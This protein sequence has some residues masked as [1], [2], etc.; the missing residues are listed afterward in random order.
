[1]STPGSG[2]PYFYEWYVGLSNV[3]EMLNPDSG[4]KSVTFQHADYDTV[5]DVVVEYTNGNIQFCYQIKHEKLTSNSTNLTFGKLIEKDSSKSSKASLI[6]S[7]FS[8]WVS[9]VSSSGMIIIPILYTNREAGI[10]RSGRTF[11]GEKYSA[12]SIHDFFTKLKDELNKINDYKNVKF[13]DKDLELQWKEFYDSIKTTDVEK[14]ISFVKALKIETNQPNLDDFEKV[15]I[16][17]LEKSFS[18]NTG[19]ATELFEK[20]VSALRKWTTAIWGGKPVLIEDAYDELVTEE[21]IC[22]AQ[23]RLAPPTPFFESRKDFCTDFIDTINSSDKKIIFVSGEPGSGKTSIMSYLQASN[24]LF[25]LRYHTFRPISPEQHFY[26]LDAGQCSPENLWGTLLIQ[27]RKKLKGHLY[28][29]NVPVNNKYLT[30]EQIREH[31]LRLLGIVS[32]Q[33]RKGERLFICIDGI[34]HAARA[35]N[36]ITFLSTLPKSVEIPD[37][38]C[39]VIV[40]QPIELYREQYPLWL[41]EEQ[42]VEKIM[43]P[44]LTIEDVIPLIEGKAGGLAEKATEVATLLFQYT[45]GN[46]LSTVFAIEEIKH[47]SCIEDIARVIS[48]RCISSDIQQYYNYIWDYVKDEIRKLNVPGIAP[49]SLVAC[50]ILLLNGQ[51][52]IRI[53]ANA[54]SQSISESDWRVIFN[55]LFPLIYETDTSGVYALFHNDFRVFLM[56]QISNYI[57]KYQGIA[58]E[59]ANYYLQNDEGIDSYVN[60]IPLFQCAQKE[61][62]IPDIFTPEYVINALAEGVSKQRLDEFAKLSYA[63]SC[64]NKN[65]QGYINT[66]LSV[67]TL[68]QHNI[69]YEFYAKSYYPNEYPELEILD[70]AEIRNLP[71][72]KENLN[73]YQSVLTLCEKLY[74]S[75]SQN[76]K[77]RAISLYNRWLACYTP[78]SFLPLFDMSEEQNKPWRYASDD[79]VKFLEH[80]GKTAVKLNQKLSHIETPENKWQSYALSTFGDAYFEECIEKKNIDLAIHAI[81]Q[82]Y[83]SHDC[84]LS[85][86]ESIYFC[87]CIDSFLNYIQQLSPDDSSLNSYL[88]S[89]AILVQNDENTDSTAINVPDFNPVTT[90][91]DDNSFEIILRAFILGFLEKDLDDA[92]VCSHAKVL[93]EHVTD[94]FDFTILQISS[95]VRFSCLLG[96]YY[97]NIHA[98]ESDVFKRFKTWFFTTKLSRPFDYLKSIRFLEFSFF[99]SP[100][101]ESFAAEDDFYKELRYYLFKVGGFCSYH[102]TTV[103]EYLKKHNQNELIYD[104]IQKLYGDNFNYITQLN[105]KREVHDVFFEYGRMVAPEVITDYSNKLKWDVVG[106]VSHKEYSLY[107]ANYYY[108]KIIECLPERALFYSNRFYSLSQIA[109]KVGNR[110]AY[111]I[112]FNIQKA[113]IKNGLLDFWKLRYYDRDFRLDPN[114]IYHSIFEFTD[115]SS[116]ADELSIL[117][118]LN[119]GIHSWY[120]QEERM[121]AINIY[122]HMVKHSAKYQIDFRNVVSSITPQWLSIID[123]QSEKNPCEKPTNEKA[124]TREDEIERIKSEYSKIDIDALMRFVPDFPALKYPKQR[125]RILID[126]LVSE[127]KLISKYAFMILNSF[128]KYLSDNVY[129]IEYSEDIIND[130]YN[131]IPEQTF[132]NIAKIIGKDLPDYGYQTSNRTISVLLRVFAG[133][134]IKKLSLL[135]ESE[136]HTQEL[137][138]SCNNHIPTEFHFEEYIEKYEQPNNLLEMSICLLLDQIKSQNARKIECALY[139]LYVF[140]LNYPEAIEIII[141]YWSVLSELQKEYILLVVYRL[142]F[143]GVNSEMIYD[144]LEQENLCC[145]VISRKMILH[146]I[147][148]KLNPQKYIAEEIQFDAPSESFSL[149]ASGYYDKNSIYESYIS[150]L[151][152]HGLS[153]QLLNRL[154]RLANKIQKS[155]HSFNEPY[156]KHEVDLI[157]PPINILM[158]KI[159]YDVE[160]KERYDN[161]PLIERKSY[162]LVKEDPFLI[163]DNPRFVFDETLIS[164]NADNIDKHNLSN[165]NNKMLFSKIVSIDLPP[166]RKVLA[167]CMWYPWNHEDGAVFYETAKLRSCW[168]PVSKDFEWSLGN[169]GLLCN[170]GDIIEEFSY[171]LSS[172]GKNLFKRVGG[173]LRFQYGNS[174]LIPSI[175]W[176][177]VLNCSPSDKTPYIWLNENGEEVL[178]FER[179][180]SPMREAMREYYIRQPIIFRWVC[181]SAWI[182]Q[183]LQELGLRMIIVSKVEEMIK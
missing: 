81:K 109:E 131:V 159:L 84:F 106:Y 15:L 31:V 75:R 59:L 38:V 140:G 55:S 76:Y 93:F 162:L 177:E 48:N 164:G 21:E 90:L 142:V 12:Y 157:I 83:I 130:I 36:T 60:A 80:W 175:L 30:I 117:W 158:E 123:Y 170:E 39:F 105:N 10:R 138:V 51:V 181:D 13:S 42:Y 151:E 54:L 72:L 179:I 101:G 132:W 4:I 24:D 176:R 22:E 150:L 114:M 156:I 66:Y 139:S 94:R 163:T 172:G 8:G 147:L 50:P 180:A 34:D 57:E 74:S 143:D 69:Y 9:A 56:G 165:S 45:Q 88:L 128:C 82:G 135:F 68:Y 63:E 7:I 107:E 161:I 26:N 5:D 53:L 98:N 104:Y 127:N 183:K 29:Y 49:E 99:N 174:Q 3:I 20:L 89:R 65:I 43:V 44:K 148:H 40:G 2:D 14:V 102:K 11:A 95:M 168:A 120:T 136:M 112:R 118:I 33:E 1:M 79:V 145:N 86:I 100:A 61:N 62:E 6:A 87:G 19:I 23:H 92:V 121:S 78:Y 103:L 166:D 129:E 64:K 126:R 35:N 149:P 115:V 182:K 16:T 46:N 71:I 134:D 28:E 70:I 58:F 96:K 17:K 155:L 25:Y 133:N 124:N 146:S 27:I 178:W 32:N 141:K 113:A 47:L 108:E 152:N 110:C 171:S 91:H 85:Q 97:H 144:F 119:C 125:F 173:V 73:D 169:F 67:K 137:W 160:K 37:G 18:C 52:N 153:S 167:G 41:S 122:N 154:R 77:E 116:C 111:D